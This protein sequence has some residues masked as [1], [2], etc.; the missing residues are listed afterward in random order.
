VGL[1]RPGS[2]DSRS[3]GYLLLAVTALG[4]SINWPAIK[5]LLRE[6]PPLFSRGV[7][8][9]VAAL[10]LAGF[11]VARRESL[12]VPGTAIPALL[13]AAFT[14]VFAWMGFSPWR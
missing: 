5:L 6:W 11:A 7:A 3:T 8:G 9:V 14:N 4:W 2:R 12:R 1:S 10:I 13:L